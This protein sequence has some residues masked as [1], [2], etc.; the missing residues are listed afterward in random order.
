[1]YLQPL[2]EPCGNVQVNIAIARICFRYKTLTHFYKKKL[3]CTTLNKKHRK[4]CLWRTRSRRFGVVDHESDSS[5]PIDAGERRSRFHST[6]CSSFLG[7]KQPPIW[8]FHNHSHWWAWKATMRTKGKEER[9]RACC[10]RRKAWACGRRAWDRMMAR[11]SGASEAGA[12]ACG[13][14]D[15]PPDR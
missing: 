9:G 5:E 6:G 8:S 10:G 4:T 15:L 14:T 2:K 12:V 3:M 13:A 7:S 1:M 11:S